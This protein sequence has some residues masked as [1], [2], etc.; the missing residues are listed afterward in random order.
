MGVVSLPWHNAVQLPV[1]PF[2]QQPDWVYDVI[3]TV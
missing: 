2:T 3:V 1:T